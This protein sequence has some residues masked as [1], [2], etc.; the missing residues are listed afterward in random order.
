MKCFL[1]YVS[2]KGPYFVRFTMVSDPPGTVMRLCLF[3]GLEFGSCAHSN[4]HF[5]V[6][7]LGHPILTSLNKH[8]E[9]IANDPIHVLISGSGLHAESS[10]GPF[11]SNSH[12]YC[13]I[14]AHAWCESR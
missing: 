5:I 6:Q 13:Q 14:N 10:L 8:V 2:T 4:M 3:E 11:H 7:M 12:N 9:G 1:Q